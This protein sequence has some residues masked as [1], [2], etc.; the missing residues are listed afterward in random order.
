[1]LT[2]NGANTYTWSFG[3][4]GVSASY[5]VTT[6]TLVSVIGTNTLSACS[7]S[8]SIIITNL[9]KPTINISTSNTLICAGET[10]TLSAAGAN[11]YSWSNSSTNSVIV[12]QPGVSTTYSVIGTNTNNCSSTNAMNITVSACT[13]NKENNTFK[14]FIYPNPATEVINISSNNYQSYTLMNSLGSIIQKGE[15]KNKNET[16]RIDQFNA[17]V[18]FIILSNS[19]ENKSH[20]FIISK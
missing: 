10:V 8:A 7:N 20:R 16:I 1:M 14:S 17:G 19:N 5:P 18:Y 15:L 11:T 12:V 9:P 6:N 13:F 3:A 2:A 4:N